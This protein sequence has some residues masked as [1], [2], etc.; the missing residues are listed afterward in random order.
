VSY[1]LNRATMEAELARAHRALVH[2]KQA[3]D[4]IGDNGAYLD[5]QMLEVEITRLAEASLKDKRSQVGRLHRTQSDLI[6]S[7]S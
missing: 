5:I 3:A 6:P 7:G 1:D 2:A 4:R